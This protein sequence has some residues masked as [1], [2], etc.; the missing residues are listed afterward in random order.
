MKISVIIPYWNSGGWLCRC[1]DSLIKQKGD[2]EF[3][4]VDDMSEDNGPELVKEYAKKDERIIPL[5]T[6]HPFGVSG[7]RNTGIENATGEWVTFLDA[8]DELLD[9]V[10][11]TIDYTIL[12]DQRANIHQFNHMRYYTA[13]NKT[14]MKQAVDGGVYNFGRLPGW[15]FGVWN[16]VYRGDFVK[17]LRFDDRIT[18][19]EDGLFALESFCRDNYIHC[20]DRQLAT[21]RHRFDNKQS[22]SRCKTVKAMTDYYFE[23]I[24]L[25]LRQTDPEIK[26]ALCRI[27]AEQFGSENLHTVIRKEGG[28]K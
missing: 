10:H 20:A 7:A 26:V 12:Q 19:G 2:F 27:I 4:M 16:K 6:T 5:A 23:L 8:D 9:R 24:N 28:T 14:K 25:M 18:Y 22:L 17:E 1:M 3:L 13:T 21:V 15:W 11:K